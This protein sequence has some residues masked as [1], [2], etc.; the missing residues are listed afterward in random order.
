MPKRSQSSQDVL[1]P[2]QQP[3]SSVPPTP[4][5]PLKPQPKPDQPSHGQSEADKAKLTSSVTKGSDAGAAKGVGGGWGIMGR[6]ASGLM[7]SGGKKATD[8]KGVS[9]QLCPSLYALNRQTCEWVSSYESRCYD[10]AKLHGT[11]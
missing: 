4:E 1:Q 6:V 2:V 3:L 7:G 8:K 11:M 9:F 10:Q 5:K